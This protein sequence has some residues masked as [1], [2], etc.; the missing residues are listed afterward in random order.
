MSPIWPEIP[1]W[2]QAIE[3]HHKITVAPELLAELQ[4]PTEIRRKKA[5]YRIL[6]QPEVII[7]VRKS[8][9]GLE[10]GLRVALTANEI[11]HW[12]DTGEWPDR[13]RGM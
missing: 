3:P 5:R 4:A 9:A 11:Q 10:R 8:L 13:M 12:L 2:L 1:Q 6:R 7:A